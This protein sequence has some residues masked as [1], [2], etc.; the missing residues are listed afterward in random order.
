MN[1]WERLVP[2]GIPLAWL[3]LVKER[4]RFL[5]ATAGITFAVTMMLFQMGLNSALFLQ[6]VSPHLKLEGDLVLVH[7]QYEY[8]GISRGFSRARLVQAQAHPQVA[9]IAP[10]YLINLPLKHPETGKGRDIL[11]MGFDP[12]DRVWRDPVIAAQQGLLKT[13][14]NVLFDAYSREEFG[15]FPAQLEAADSVPTELNE[16]AVEVVGT[17][18]MGTTFAADGNL[19][20]GL[21]TF[22]RVFPG[23]R[24]G[25]VSVGLVHL[26]EGAEAAVVAADL[27]ERLLGDVR[28]LTREAFIEGEKAYWATRTPIGFVIAASMTVALIVGAVIVYQILYT[29]VNDHLEEYATLKSIGFHD[30]YFNSLILQ[31]STILSILGFLPG[32]GLTAVLYAMTRHFAYMP[33]YLSWEKALTVF[34]LTL[35]M[36]LV[37]GAFATRKLRSANPA[38]IF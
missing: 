12:A 5:A 34:G 33:T 38:D 3:N 6:V 31:E 16:R 19:V 32:L 23:S 20:C 17:F 8:F 10:V 4:K 22:W 11:V 14:G 15:P 27:R 13:P 2:L 24:P 1:L 7:P 35:L 36:C 18:E 9:D 25:R 21:E 28:V 30:R 26:R 37:A 29:D